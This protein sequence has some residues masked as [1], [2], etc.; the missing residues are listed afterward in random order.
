L[1]LYFAFRDSPSIP[2]D[3]RDNL[4]SD[5]IYS[6]SLAPDDWRN[7]TGEWGTWQYTMAENAYWEFLS[8]RDA[9]SNGDYDNAVARI[10]IVLHYVGDAIEMEHSGGPSGEVSKSGALDDGVRDW[11]RN[12]VDPLGSD[13]PLWSDEESGA[14]EYSHRVRQQIE[15][16][17]DSDSAWYPIK[18]ESYGQTENVDLGTDDGSLDWF[19]AYFYDLAIDNDGPNSS[20]PTN[21]YAYTALGRHIIQ[22]SPYADDPYSTDYKDDN[23]WLSWVETRD[24][25]ISKMDA[26]NTIRLVYNGVYRAIRDAYIE[27]GGTWAWPTGGEYSSLNDN[28]YGEGMDSMRWYEGTTAYGSEGDGS[29]QTVYP[30]PSIAQP[31]LLTLALIVSVFFVGRF[32]SKYIVH[33]K[34]KTEVHHGRT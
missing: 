24:P 26:D 16:Y 18:P 23:R 13:A 20:G 5:T 6:L 1:I 12:F 29:S 27:A 14:G 22:T 25:A 11:Y 28:L 34:S 8:I 32:V 2:N 17:T 19:L 30:S 10:G 15:R 9:W 21:I 31:M 33:R 7:V 3:V 4:D